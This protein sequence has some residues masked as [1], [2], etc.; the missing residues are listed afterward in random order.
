M[1]AAHL[2]LDEST[3]VALAEIPLG[4]DAVR[5]G[6]WLPGSGVFLCWNLFTLLGD[7]GAHSL[8]NRRIVG[9]RHQIGAVI[10]P[11]QWLA[12]ERFQRI[13]SL[14]PVVLLSGLVVAKNHIVLDH[15]LAGVGA[16]VVSLLAKRPFIVVVP[17]ATLT[18]DL[19]FR[20]H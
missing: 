2:T 14:V 13:N 10:V 12:N 15:R 5:Q 17:T 16:A 4:S 19:V 1:P 20:W 9:T 6:F 3:N 8:G 18:G 7:L 11:G